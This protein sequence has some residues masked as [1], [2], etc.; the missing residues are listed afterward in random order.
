MNELL[1]FSLISI[2]S[3]YTLFLSIR[4]PSILKL[5]FSALIINPDD[6]N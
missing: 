2:V 5:L 6:T 4:Y 1:G 3:I